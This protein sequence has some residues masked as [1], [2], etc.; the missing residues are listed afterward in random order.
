[1]QID[2]GMCTARGQGTE[3]IEGKEGSVLRTSWFLACSHCLAGSSVPPSHTR[4]SGLPRPLL[5]RVTTAF[6]I[7]NEMPMRVQTGPDN[8]TTDVNQSCLGKAGCVSSSL[9][10]GEMQ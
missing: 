10:T 1:M 5:T 8:K 6:I 3:Q 2:V 7:L 9:P 4:Q